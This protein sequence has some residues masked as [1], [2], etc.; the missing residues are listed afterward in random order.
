M[1]T[2]FITKDNREDWDLALPYVMMAYRS[3]P[4]ESTGI[5]PNMM[6]LGRELTLP[7]DLQY[8]PPECP[9]LEYKCSTTYVEWVRSIQR[10]AHELARTYLDNAAVRQRRYYDLGSR[11]YDIEVGNW[12]YLKDHA[13]KKTKLAPRWKGP[14]LVVSKKS[15]VTYGIQKD[16]DDP[17]AVHH[18]DALKKCYG[19]KAKKWH[20]PIKRTVATQ[21]D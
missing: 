20:T 6:M 8:P 18:V 2:A 10:E 15:P 1:L 3:T 7:L 12:V 4:N 5:T 17:V 9:N 16:A 19:H 21:S 14:Y 11:S 13:N